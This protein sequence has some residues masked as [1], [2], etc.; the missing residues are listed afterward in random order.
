MKYAQLVIGPAGSGKS[1]Y[2]ATIQDHCKTIGRS[3]FVVNLD[4]AAENFA[5]NCDVDIRELISVEDVLDD[6]EIKMGPNGALIFCMEYFV[7]NLEW[8]KEQLQ[9]G[10]DDYFLFDSLSTI[11]SFTTPSINVLS[12]LDL[13]NKEEKSF[14]KNF[15]EDEEL[16]NNLINSIDDGQQ[17]KDKWTEKYSKLTQSL[18]IVLN[19]YSLV[20]FL[21][22]DISDE[23]SIQELLSVIDVTIQYGEDADVKDRFPQFADN[24][25]DY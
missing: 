15:L 7:K 22:L 9:E 17:Q 18:L 20:K 1:T 19:D 4:P 3:I 13:L 2:C 21:P 5:Y 24:L 25:D 12:K 14:V 10:E 16:Q 11:V 8:L 6:K 23:D